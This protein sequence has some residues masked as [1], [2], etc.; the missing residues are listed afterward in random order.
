MLIGIDATRANKPA[1]TGVEWYAHH[2]IQELKTCTTGDENSWILYSNAVLHGGLEVLPE[3]W[4]EVRMK[5][6]FPIGWTQ[7][8]LSFELSRRTP[9]VLWMPGST[10]PRFVPTHTVVTVHDV[11]FHRFPHLYKPHQVKIHEQ[12]MKEIAKKAARILTVSE[13]AGREISETYGIDPGKIAITY[14]GIDHE[15]YRRIDDE[16]G[17]EDRLRRMQLPKPFFIAIG[18]L[19]AKKNITTLIKA[20][21]SFK[22]RLG[23]GSPYHLALVGPRGFGYAAIADEIA[24]SPYRSEIHETGYVPEADLPYLLN[25][26]DALIHPSWVEGFGIPPVEAMAC[27][28]PVIASNVASLPEI[29]GDAALFF[30]PSEPE[31]LAQRMRRVVE[32]ISV[33]DEL[34]RKG[35]E[36]AN[37]F[38]WTK[39]AQHT[40]PVLTRW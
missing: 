10:L 25:A 28:C 29:L 5:W 3:N 18:R 14:L 26:A 9:D 8:R 24:R 36:R 11:G 4:Y 6:P 12:A 40:V 32:E 2:V 38:T 31:Q 1:K 20:F 37:S 21:N 34:R 39:T 27:G 23:V 19:E 16:A 35:I 7:I 30:S 13:Y 17:I 22:A 33:K 15:A